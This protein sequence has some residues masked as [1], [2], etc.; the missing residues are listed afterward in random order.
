MRL[1][2]NKWY[3]KA[4]I[5]ALVLLTSITGIAFAQ[6]DEKIDYVALGDSLSVGYTP[7]SSIDKSY[8]DFIAMKLDGEGILGDYHNFGVIRYTTD[9]VLASID[10]TN[11]QN[12]E[13]ILAISN[14][15]IIT[16]DIGA[17]DILDLIPALMADP[18]QAPDVIQ[19][20]A[21]NLAEIILTLKGI[22][23][24]A[25]I[26]LMGY[27]NAFPFYPEELQEQV[28]PL[29]KGLNLA[30]N[31]VANATG[32]TY[33]DTYTIMDKHLTK[34]LPEDD[35]HPGLLGYKAMAKEFWNII[36]VDF[37]RGIN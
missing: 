37:L 19:S 32:E 15:E 5:L 3:L 31:Q 20:I 35:I 25:N 12:A 33:I 34:Y 23:P 8:T 26:Y 9:D 18:T 21:E 7:Y 13:S 2:S 36:K 28:I 14:A 4:V 22:N 27:Y 17:N 16:L 11:P 10:Y 30:I 1:Y 6:S 29:I 24:N